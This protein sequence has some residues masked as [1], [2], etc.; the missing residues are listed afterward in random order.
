MPTQQVLSNFTRTGPHD[1]IA[2]NYDVLYTNYEVVDIHHLTL[3]LLTSPPP[4]PSSSSSPLL[5]LT[6]QKCPSKTTITSKIIRDC[7]STVSNMTLKSC[8]T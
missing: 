3:H 6:P 5:L 2:Y 7:L 4:H 8:S 1:V